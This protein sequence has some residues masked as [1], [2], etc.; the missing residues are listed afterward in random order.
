M[1]LGKN[2]RLKGFYSYIDRDEHEE[3]KRISKIQRRSISDI[4]R[5]AISIYIAENKDKGRRKKILNLN[6]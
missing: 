6:D 4:T 3:L 1:A 2:S 5:E